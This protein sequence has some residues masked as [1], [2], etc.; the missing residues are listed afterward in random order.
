MHSSVIKPENRDLILREVFQEF[1]TE[2]IF[3]KGYPFG[4]GHIHDTFLVET[5]GTDNYV[6]QR[7]NSRVFKKIPEMQENIERVTLHIRRK[8]QSVK[9]SDIRRECLNFIY[10]TNGKTWIKDRSGDYWRLSVF[11]PDHRTYETVD[12]PEKAFEG[13]KAI[14][15]FQE[16]LADLGGQ[17]LHETI[18]YF[19]HAGKR[20]ETFNNKINED[21]FSRVRSVKNEIE[22]LLERAEKM[23]IIV[24]L[25][26]EGRI[27]QRIIHYDTKFNNILFDEHDK[28]LCLI[29]LDTVMPGYIHYDFG[30]A[31]RTGASISAEDEPDLLKVGMNINLFR[32]YAEGY[33]KEIRATLNNTEIDYLAFSPMLITYIQAVRFL[34]D[35][36][37]GDKYYKIHYKDHNL[38]RTKAQNQLVR[39]MEEQYTGMQKIISDL[40]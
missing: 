37:D 29:D 19:H 32:S 33:L 4:S 23:Q 1:Q 18:P 5:G 36:I 10:A 7:L 13:G 38:V 11:I 25:G 9:G 28:A 30:D 17:P 14:G 27:P 39:S 16:M 26:N 20:L 34:T 40:T 3:I 21:P 6:L 22:F 15:R 35:Y 12:S 2:G 31:I 8:L 24:R